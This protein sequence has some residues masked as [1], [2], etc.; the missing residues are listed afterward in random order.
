MSVIIPPPAKVVDEESHT[1]AAASSMAMTGAGPAEWV[2]G[3]QE[4]LIVTCLSVI[5]LVVALD[6]SII[7]TSL[8][9]SFFY[10]SPKR[11]TLCS[12]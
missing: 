3:K 5:S 7:V 12:L 10:P 11:R 6:A 4:Y 1:A 9:V 8:P 2:S